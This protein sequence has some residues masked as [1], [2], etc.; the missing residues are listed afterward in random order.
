MWLIRWGL[1]GLAEL[2]HSYFNRFVTFGF[3]LKGRSLRSVI[4][5][6]V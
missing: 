2:L 3:A 6:A 4:G 1:S 5:L